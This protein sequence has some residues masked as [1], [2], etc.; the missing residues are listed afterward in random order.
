MELIYELRGH[1]EKLH[2][3]IFEIR[4]SMKSCM[5]MQMKLQRSIKQDVAAA[6]SQLGEP[7][8]K[9]LNMEKA[10][11]LEVCVLN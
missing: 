8:H 1:M 4:R 9:D 10:K 2:Q 7:E 6:I 5:N 11:I 3:E